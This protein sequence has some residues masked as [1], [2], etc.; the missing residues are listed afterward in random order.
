M[1]YQICGRF[2]LTFLLQ[3]SDIF[4]QHWVGDCEGAVEW[5][6]S[7]ED[8]ENQRWSALIFTS[9][10]FLNTHKVTSLRRKSG[11]ISYSRIYVLDKANAYGS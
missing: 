3:H 11:D 5:S 4:P 10:S 6:H 2:D 9:Q 7:E 8:S 1:R